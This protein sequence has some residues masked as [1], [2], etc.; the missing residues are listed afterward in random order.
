MPSLALADEYKASGTTTTNNVKKQIHRAIAANTRV[1]VITQKA[2]MDF[3]AKKLLCTHRTVL[4]DEHLEPFFACKWVMRNHLS[5]LDMFKVEAAGKDG[6]Y[7]VT[8]DKART[9]QFLTSC[10]ML[11]NRQFIKDL[12]ATQQRIFTNRPSI[13]AQSVLFRVVSPS[14]YDNADAVNIACA[15]FTCTRQYQLWTALFDQQWKMTR[16]FVPYVTPNLTLHVVQQKRNSKTHNQYNTSV[17]DGVVAYIKSKCNDPVYIDNNVYDDLNGWSRVDHNCHGVNEHREK[18]H[19]AILSAVNYDNLA[20]AFLIDMAGMTSDSVRN[21]L[22]G[23]IAHQ[24]IMRGALRSDN[25]NKCHVYLMESD[26]GQYLASHVFKGSQE[27]TIDDTARPDRKP[28]LTSVERK[29]ATLIRKNF[30]QYKEMPTEELMLEAVWGNTNTNGV[31]SKKYLAKSPTEMCIGKK[32][33]K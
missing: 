17:R 7:E 16:P 18:A 19:I 5:W 2:F 31:Y 24:V 32:S 23:D 9:D 30:A 13:H 20:T 33:N 15:N 10:D 22:V 1:I 29:K 8:L 3:E 26:L 28:A 21:S 25:T 12:L 11:D 27:A 14:I 6:W 4:Q